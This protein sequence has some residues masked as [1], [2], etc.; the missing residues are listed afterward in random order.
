MASGKQ[1]I[2]AWRRAVRAQV[3]RLQEAKDPS[4][5]ADDNIDYALGCS[6]MLCCVLDGV[7][8]GSAGAAIGGALNLLGASAKT[9]VPIVPN[10]FFI[11][12]GHDDDEDCPLTRNYM[13]SRIWKGAGAT[14]ITLTGAAASAGTYGINV[15]DIGVQANAVGSTAAHIVQLS[16]IAHANRQTQTISRWLTAILFMKSMKVGVRGTQLVGSALPAASLGAG[17]AAAVAKL[18]LKLTTANVCMTTAMAIHWRA[19]QEQAIGRAFAGA[20]RKAGPGT[21]IFVELFQRRGATRVFGQYDA[22]GLI[23]EPAGYLALNDKISLI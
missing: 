2:E 7:S 21:R 6:D 8:G 3:Q 14:A 13:K 23:R 11:L 18:G 15:L 17:I 20:G 1:E 5:Q 19:Y 10:P 9:G 12:N 16:R 22:M 4:N